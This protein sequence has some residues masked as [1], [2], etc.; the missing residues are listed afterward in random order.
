M[1]FRATV[2]RLFAAGVLLA[3]A[4]PAAAQQVY[5][6]KPIRFIVPYP[7]GGGVD[8]IA[9]MAAQQLSQNWNQPVIVDNRPGGNTIIGT[10]AVAR[11]PADG[12]TLLAATSTFVTRPNLLATPY[13][14][15]K[16]FAPVATIATSRHV[17]VLH[18]SVP[19]NTLQELIALVKAKPGQ[20][21]Y[22]TLG[23]GSVQHLLGASL[24]ILAGIKLQHIAYKG[25]SQS[26]VDMLNGQ[27]QLSFQVPMSVSAHLKN[28]KLKAIAMIGESRNATLPQVPTFTEAGL[29][30]L[31]I[32]LWFG[33]IARAGTPKAVIDR[34]SAEFA[35]FLTEPDFKEMLVGQGLEPFVS[36]P[37]QF[38]A[39]I[40]SDFAHYAKVIRI[41][42][43][44]A[45][46]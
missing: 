34:L 39:L 10:E 31:D 43:I 1:N 38:A 21:N 22:V 4:C 14:P 13:D 18:P 8:P 9:R 6:N 24:E 27:V 2:K 40:K 17:L 16:D 37:D 25:T 23:S 15:I 45:D 7:P 32:K 42:N 33:V 5:P 36:T 20:L 28:G 12:Y 41:A 19:A 11:A 26:L 30:G 46:E 44:K 35:K 29:P 3:L